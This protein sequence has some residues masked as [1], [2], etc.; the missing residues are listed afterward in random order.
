MALALAALQCSR[1]LKNAERLYLR[2]LTANASEPLQCS[3][4]L[5]NAERRDQAQGAPCRGVH[6]S[7]QPRSEERGEHVELRDL[8]YLDTELQCSRV[9]KNAE[10]ALLAS[11]SPSYRG[12]FNAAAF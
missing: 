7:M 4:V 2:H 1:V 5:K 10:S 11:D 3:R 6:A 9:L 8:V 12:R